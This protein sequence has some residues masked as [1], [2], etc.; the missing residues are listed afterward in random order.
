MISKAKE[1]QL[2]TLRL[3][4]LFVGDIVDSDASKVRLAGLRAEASEFSTEKSRPSARAGVAIGEGLK[5]FGSVVIGVLGA[6]AA[7]LKIFQFEVAASTA[8]LGDF[9]CYF[10][11]LA[12]A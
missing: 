2:K 12:F 10:G 4:H 5:N 6:G 7:K 8:G 11:R 9:L 3:H 1:V